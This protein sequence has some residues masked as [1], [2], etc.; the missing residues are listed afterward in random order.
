MSS[1]VRCHNGQPWVITESH[2]KCCKVFRGCELAHNLDSNFCRSCTSLCTTQFLPLSNADPLQWSCYRK[3][4]W[5]RKMCLGDSSRP[6]CRGAGG[7]TEARPSCPVR[8]V[9]ISAYSDVLKSFKFLSYC[10][11]SKNTRSR[12][13]HSG[14]KILGYCALVRLDYQSFKIVSDVVDINRCSHILEYWFHCS[15]FVVIL[16]TRYCGNY[17]CR[18]I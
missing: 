9:S 7:E 8:T 13:M 3:C 4:R 15:Y 1:K 16:V 14:F 6:A 12:S 2:K 18:R 10:R 5:G 17:D 11:S